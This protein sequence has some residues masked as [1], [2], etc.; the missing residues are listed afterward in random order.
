MKTGLC[1]II[2]RENC[3]SSV[4]PAGF[5]AVR[6]YE[7]VVIL[8][9]ECP[10][11]DFARVWE[12]LKA[13]GYLKAKVEQSVYLKAEQ[14]KDTLLQIEQQKTRKFG[15]AQIEQPLV[16]PEKPRFLA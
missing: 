7:P 3:L 10:A 14:R 15:I 2:V 6:K 12:D 13:R 1:K 11:S 5:D 16:F 9:I 8:E 4:T